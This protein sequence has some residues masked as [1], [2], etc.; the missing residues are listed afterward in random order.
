MEDIPDKLRNKFPH[1]RSTYWQTDILFP[2]YV[3]R[4]DSLMQQAKSLLR[5]LLK[6]QAQRE[7]KPDESPIVFFCWGTAGGI[8]LKQVHN[9]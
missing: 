1:G 7:S 6:S 4:D 8:L 2:P 5:E 9:E 3:R